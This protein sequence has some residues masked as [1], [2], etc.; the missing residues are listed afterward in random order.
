MHDTRRR[1]IRVIGSASVIAAAPQTL[2]AC[3]PMPDEATEAWRRAGQELDPR[4][5]L[6]S[7]AILAPNPHNRQPWLV[8]LRAPDRI[9]LHCDLERL[10]PMTDPPG[11]QITIGHGCFLELLAQAAGANGLRAEITPF[12][13]GEP[14]PDALDAR[15]VARIDLAPGPV[16]RDPLFD[17]V[18]ARGTYRKPFAERKVARESLEALVAAAARPAVRVSATQEPAMVA[19]LNQILV[20]AWELEQRT[21]RV[22]KESVD[23]MRVGSSEIARHRDGIALG[24]TMIEIIRLLG[25]TSPKA[26]MDP[27][28]MF[29]AEGLNRVYDWAPNTGSYAW[30]TTGASGRAAQL[31]AGRA[32]VRLQLK[33]AELGLVTQPPSQVLQEFAEMDALRARFE[34]LVA[35]PE[36]EKTQMLVRIGYSDVS[37]ARSARR[38]LESMLRA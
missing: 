13:E 20:Q 23:L 35:Q 28:S 18:L 16:V 11:R 33:A 2:G 22:W 1:F 4:R 15:P 27:S 31:E 9:V 30:L 12:P 34:R 14:G 7:W 38:P 10:L 3:A 17:Q 25:M 37:E 19:Q 5:R 32:F 26:M 29:F 6:L 36:G 8:D 21:P 24:G